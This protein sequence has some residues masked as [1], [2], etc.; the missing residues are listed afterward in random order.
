MICSRWRRCPG[1]RASSFTRAA[2]FL[3]RQTPSWMVLLPTETENP[4]S[5]LMRTASSLLEVP[6]LSDSVLILGCRFATITTP[7]KDNNK[8][9]NSEISC[10][11]DNSLRL[12]QHRQGQPVSTILGGNVQNESSPCCVLCSQLVD[13]SESQSTKEIRFRALLK[14]H[15]PE[16][17]LMTV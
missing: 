6:C 7:A 17:S 14:Q 5:N 13:R 4:P 8:D 9:G 2:A 15:G 16:L 1:A 12:A 11:D 10:C 3:K